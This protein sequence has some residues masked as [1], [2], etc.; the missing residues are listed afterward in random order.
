MQSFSIEQGPQKA[1][2]QAGG[3]E[4]NGP[5]IKKIMSR[6][7]AKKIIEDFKLKIC[8]VDLEKICSDDDLIESIKEKNIALEKYERL[9][10]NAVMT[11]LVFWSE[12]KDCLC[13]KLIKPVKSGE[14]SC[15][16]LQY[17]SEISLTQ[18]KGQTGTDRIESLINTVSTLTGR[19][20]QIIGAIKNTD[21]DI[22]V[23]CVNFFDM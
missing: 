19:S 23:A 9:I 10:E 20:K 8:G 2:E 3:K 4:N 17:S 1:A 5:V 7:S 13:Q 11:G 22:M 16:V 15:T 21:V 6:E 18:M 12:E 14:Q